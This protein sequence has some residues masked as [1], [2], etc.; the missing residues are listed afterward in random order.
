[1][2]A[3]R[4]IRPISNVVPGAYRPVDASWVRYVEIEGAGIP[5]WVVIPLTIS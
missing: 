2:F 4:S 5:G 3:T 1:V